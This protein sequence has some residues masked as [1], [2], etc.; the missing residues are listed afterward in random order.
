MKNCPYCAEEIQDDAIKCKFCGEWL[1]KNSQSY[2]EP[3]SNTQIVVVQSRKSRGVAAC[4]AIFLGGIGIH[5]F[6]LNQSGWGIIYLICSVTLIPAI[7]GFIEG[8]I[9]AFMSDE[10][11]D[12]RF[13]QFSFYQ[14][15][16]SKTT[17]NQQIA[18]NNKA[19]ESGIIYTAIIVW[20]SAKVR[21]EPNS[22]SRI[23]DRLSKGV[24]VEVVNIS[25][26][27]VK[28]VVPDSDLEGWMFESSLDRLT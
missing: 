18:S 27:W 28:V 13:N 24:K 25:D 21:S 12:K 8:L 26:Q 5:K 9:Y 10:E 23:L 17:G 2:N 7:A 15:G 1:E 22:T 4:L 11:F 3:L 16:V 14:R 6:Y 19:D 20:D